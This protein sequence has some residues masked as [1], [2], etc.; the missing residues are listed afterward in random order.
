M[1]KSM[2]GMESHCI[3]PPL[4]LFMKTVLRS[5][6]GPS[7]MNG[8]YLQIKRI[9]LN[10][11]SIL[12]CIHY[13][14]ADLNTI[15]KH[16]A[17]TSQVRDLDF[18][19]SYG[20]LASCSD[21]RIVKIFDF[22]T[23]KPEL[24][25]EGHRSDVKTCAWHPY[26]SM[27]VSAGRDPE[28]KFWDPKSGNEVYTIQSHYNAINK[29]RWNKNGN[30]CLSGSKDTSTKIYDVRVMKDFITFQAH[31]DEINALEW[32]PDCEELFVSGGGDGMVVFWMANEDE[33]Y[34]KIDKAHYRACCDLVWH[35]IRNFLATAVKTKTWCRTCRSKN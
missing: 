21:D 10:L 14:T 3:S 19:S 28:I 5:C 25:F 33:A 30:W 18:S 4:I 29:V 2:F 26:E 8:L 1:G 24:Q 16:Q 20:K 11:C 13:W 22:G 12:G 35:S 27:I 6:N 32:H 23:F 7:T 34:Y 17:H 31:E 15:A 9:N